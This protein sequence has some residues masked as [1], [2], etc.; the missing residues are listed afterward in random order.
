MRLY[1]LLLLYFNIIKA[2]D[3]WYYDK[4]DNKEHIFYADTH[5]QALQDFVY[6]KRNKY[7]IVYI[8]HFK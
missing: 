5:I 8:H 7:K 1:A 3:I 4:A 2:I 6:L